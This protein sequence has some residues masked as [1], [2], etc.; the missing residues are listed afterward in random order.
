MPVSVQVSGLGSGFDPDRYTFRATKI[1]DRLI[2]EGD[3]VSGWFPEASPIRAACPDRED[4]RGDDGVA[5]PAISEIPG[6]RFLMAG[7]IGIR[8]WG[9]P[10]I[11]RELVQYADGRI[12]SKWM[13]EIMPATEAPNPAG[14][15]AF[16]APEQ[17]TDP[18]NVDRRA[19][20]YALGVIL[21][22][23]VT[24]RPPFDGE[25]AVEIVGKQLRARPVPPRQ[26]G[27]DISARCERVIL[28]ALEKD[29]AKRQQTAG[30]IRSRGKSCFA[31]KLSRFV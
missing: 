9:G 16:M 31:G 11:L 22:E 24:G 28:R 8:G 6:R 25:T 4:R 12:G 20:I 30:E 23:L 29:P 19:D 1:P 7:W 13:K 2:R 10:L 18:E 14:T 15:A 17:I 5:V 26:L 27:A 21:Y 3:R